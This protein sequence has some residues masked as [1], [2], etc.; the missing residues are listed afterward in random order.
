MCVSGTLALMFS[1]HHPRAWDGL[2][3]IQIVAVTTVLA[4]STRPVSCTHKDSLSIRGIICLSHLWLTSI[5]APPFL[6]CLPRCHFQV[7]PG[8]VLHFLSFPEGIPAVCLFVFWAQN[9]FE[10]CS[11]LFRSHVPGYPGFPGRTLKDPSL[12]A[13]LSY[14]SFPGAGPSGLSH[15]ADFTGYIHLYSDELAKVV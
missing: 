11:L 7:R 10:E 4:S 6:T 3:T 15:H 13:V 5:P 8:Q 1:V 9:S 2:W 12:A 14:G